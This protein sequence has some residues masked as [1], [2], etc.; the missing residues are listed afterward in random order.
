MALIR[1]PSHMRNPW[2]TE[3]PSRYEV[4]LCAILNWVTDLEGNTLNSEFLNLINCIY[5]KKFDI[6]GVSSRELAILLE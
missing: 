6:L 3:V 5:F 4:I 2:K 1:R